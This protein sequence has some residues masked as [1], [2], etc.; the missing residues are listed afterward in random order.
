[1]SSL[2]TVSNKGDSVVK[3]SSA[4]RAVEDTRGVKLEDSFVGLNGDRDW[5]LGKSSLG[6]GGA[7]WGGVN[8]VADIDTSVFESIVH[9]ASISGS[10]WV[11]ISGDGRVV[12]VVVESSLLETSIATEVQVSSS[13][14]VNELLLR[15]L[16]KVSGGDVVSSLQSTNR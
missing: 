4:S 6:L 3:V 16:E 5:L 1:L 14:T 15:E 12:L 7:S 13:S 9:A 2:G 8:V 10:V 11:K